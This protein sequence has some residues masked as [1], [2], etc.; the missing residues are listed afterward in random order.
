MVAVQP[1]D[2]LA[3]ALM[4]IILFIPPGRYLSAYS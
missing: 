1:L 4:G 2:E 3:E